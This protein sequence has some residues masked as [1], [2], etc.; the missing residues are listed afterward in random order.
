M[1]KLRHIDYDD[2]AWLVGSIV[3][4]ILVWWIFYGRKKYSAKGMK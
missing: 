4:P 3:V 1:I 2:K